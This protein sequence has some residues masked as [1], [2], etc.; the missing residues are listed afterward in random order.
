MPVTGGDGTPPRRRGWVV[1]T[2]LAAVVVLL[3]AAAAF[4][5]LRGTNEPTG[6]ATPSASASAKPSAS[7]T[8]DNRT[9]STDPLE[10]RLDT[11]VVNTSFTL[12]PE[13][14][15]TDQ[16]AIAAGAREALKGTYS[17]GTTNVTV[18][19]AAFDTIQAQDVYSQQVA[20]KQE[21]GGA[22]L[23]GEGSVYANDTGHYWYFVEQDGTTTTIVWRTDDGVVLTLSGPADAVQTVYRNMLI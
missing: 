3:A 13:G 21:S 1:P 5:F 4:L 9:V 15:A 6:Q 11:T 8:P 16:D 19:A 22:T 7:P 14:W 10:P 17:D 12:T 18:T 2:V 20:G 23:R